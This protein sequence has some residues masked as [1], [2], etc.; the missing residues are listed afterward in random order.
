MAGYSVSTLG[1]LTF[2]VKS[3]RQANIY[4]E[5]EDAEVDKLVYQW[6]RLQFMARCSWFCMYPAT[7]VCNGL[8]TL[9]PDQVRCWILAGSGTENLEIPE[10]LR[11]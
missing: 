11:L 7:G 10:T 4:Q 2:W 9:C 1:N 5:Q 6:I 3:S 8:T